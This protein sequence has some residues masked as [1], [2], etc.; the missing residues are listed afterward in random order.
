MNAPPVD[1]P[2]NPQRYE[3]MV[4]RFNPLD[5]IFFRG[6]DYISDTIR[7]LEKATTGLNDFSH[8]GMLVNTEIRPSVKQLQKE[9]WYVWESTMS[10]T[11]GIMANYADNQPNMETGTGKFGVQIRDLEHVVSTYTGKGGRVAWASLYNNPWHRTTFLPKERKKLIKNIRS[12][13]REVGD[14]SY[15]ANFLTLLAVI[16]PCLRDPR[17]EFEEI[18]TEGHSVLVSW[19]I[20]KAKKNDIGP[21]GWLF[22]SELV[23]LIYQK[24]GLIPPDKDPRNVL[25]VDFLG[26]DVDGIPRL[27]DLPLYIKSNSESESTELNAYPRITTSTSTTQYA[28]FTVTSEAQVSSF[29]TDS[30]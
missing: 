19:G 5:L 3:A 22:C 13:H 27:V 29:T 26:V 24:I 16:I 11:E 10:E 30:Q 18:L 28:S 8:V 2:Y 20:H 12:L 6:T 4:L 7:V 1:I 14:R 15:N 25:P 9:R 21:A 17:D 23:A